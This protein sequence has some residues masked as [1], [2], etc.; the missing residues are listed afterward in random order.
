[1]LYR[2][3]ALAFAGAGIALMSAGRPV[4][5]ADDDVAKLIARIKAAGPEGSGNQDVAAAWQDLV[6]RGADALLPTLL[7]LGEVEPRAANWLRPAID[8]IVE[9]EKKAGRKLPLDRLEQFVKDTKK[10]PVSRRVAYELLARDDQ[11][12]SERL[13]PGM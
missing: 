6:A 13:L 8:S 1:M 10:P 9:A 4:A 3:I 11:Q 5:A 2:W 7:A 12:A